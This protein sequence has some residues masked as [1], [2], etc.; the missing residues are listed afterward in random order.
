MAHIE[1]KELSLA[2]IRKTTLVVAVEEEKKENRKMVKVMPEVEL[3]SG[4]KMPLLGMGTA[5]FPVPSDD[6]ATTAAVIAAIELGYRHFD[7]ACVYGSE[8]AV[9]KAIAAALER[10]LIGSRQ[11]IFVTTKLWCTDMYADAVVPALQE[12]IRNLGLEYVDLYLIH[13]PVRLKGEKNMVFTSESILPMEDLPRVWEAME[14]CQALGFAKSIGVSNFT[15]HKLSHF[16]PHAKIPPAVNQVE[17][18][19]LWQQKKLREFCTEKGIHVS[20]YSPLGAI[21]VLWGTNAVLDCDEVKRIAQSTGKTRA[22]VCLKWGLEQGV[23]VIVKSFNRERLKENMEIFDWKLSEEDKE[24]LSKLP[25]KRYILAEPFVS[26]NG[27]YKSHAE[28]WDGEI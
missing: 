3:S 28:M 18:H 15:L 21:G 1:Y 25:Q 9:G 5:T 12:S 4:R 19:P 16:L 11:E 27:F 22:Q 8:R 13:Y 10:G 23:S 17:M 26:P 14:R 24:R 2:K 7:T 6:S 20:A